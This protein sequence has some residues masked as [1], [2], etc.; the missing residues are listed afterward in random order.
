[1]TALLLERDGAIAFERVYRF[2][3]AIEDAGARSVRLAPIDRASP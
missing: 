3:Q 2:V 1:M